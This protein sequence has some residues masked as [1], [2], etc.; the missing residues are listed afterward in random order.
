VF[1]ENYAL[2]ITVSL[3]SLSASIPVIPAQS[4][5]L[6]VAQCA[7]VNFGKVTLNPAQARA[8]A[9][10][11]RQIIDLCRTLPMPLRDSALLAIQQH[12]TGFQ[13]N[14]LMNFFT[15]FYVPSWS[16]IHWMQEASPTLSPAELESAI[17][18]QGIA[19]F[20]HMLDDHISDGQIPVSHLLLQLR[21][22]AWMTF[23]TIAQKLV[24][25][26]ATGETIIQTTLDRYFTGIHNP[27]VVN[28][29]EAYAN[30]FRQQLSTTL[31]IPLIVAHRTGQ[32][33]VPLQS[34]YEEFCIAWRLLDDLRD[35]AED[36]FSGQQSA[37]YHLLTPE[38]QALWHECQGKDE[39][40]AAW[41]I[42]QEYLEQGG[43]LQTLV[44]QT[45]ERLRR[46]EAAAIVA[47]LPNYAAE[48]TA[49]AQPLIALISTH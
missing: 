22:H 4:V 49:L 10:M 46:A 12:F 24:E 13:L 15:K 5:K 28:S 11:N 14:N 19:Y 17:G 48:M 44:E 25:P 31:V 36:T 21:T 38:Y 18:A 33:I 42:L 27:T 37:I 32:G 8:L 47:G 20:L 16:L 29:S 9:A 45:I 6:T 7:T 43:I 2:N 26:I 23:T 34:A 35:C 30:L 41:P 1:D 39:T 40:A 3:M